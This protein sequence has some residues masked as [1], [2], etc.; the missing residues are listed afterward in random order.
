MNAVDHFRRLLEYEAH[1][2]SDVLASLRTLKDGGCAEASFHEALNCFG[3]ILAVRR[4]W[5]FRLGRLKDPPSQVRSTRVLFG[6][7]EAERDNLTGLWMDF[8]VNLD[9]EELGRTFTYRTEEGKSV[10]TNV[11]DALVHVVNHSSYHRG[12]IASL[13]LAAGG[14]PPAT[15]YA[16]FT[17]RAAA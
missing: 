14:E 1:V 16:E 4:L 9:Q 5:L 11:A 15:G 17:S 2:N 6:R 8:G 13:I 3:H 12:Q 7:L 10:T